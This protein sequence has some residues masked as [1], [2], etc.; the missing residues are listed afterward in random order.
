MKWHNVTISFTGL[1]GQWGQGYT[2]TQETWQRV[3]KDRSITTN[4]SGLLEKLW[5]TERPTSP[6]SWQTTPRQSFMWGS[7]FARLTFGIKYWNKCSEQGRIWLTAT[8]FKV[9]PLHVKEPRG[10]R[11]FC[12]QSHQ[13]GLLHVERHSSTSACHSAL[14]AQTSLCSQFHC[15]TNREKRCIMP[16]CYPNDVQIIFVQGS[17]SMAKRSH[18]SALQRRKRGRGKDRYDTQR[19]NKWNVKNMSCAVCF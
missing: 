8:P 7:G 3:D 18:G 5:G 10:E 11:I 12:Q 9:T 15:A 14:T 19:R 6:P 4:S 2:S 17:L 13:K 1:Q 16:S